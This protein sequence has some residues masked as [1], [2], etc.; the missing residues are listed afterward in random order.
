MPPPGATALRVL[1]GPSA[2]AVFSKRVQ[3]E[4]FPHLDRVPV[5]LAPLAS[6]A[7][8][9]PLLPLLVLMAKRLLL[10]LRLPLI[11]LTAPLVASARVESLLNVVPVR[12]PLLELVFVLVA[13]QALSA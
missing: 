13:L 12:F 4:A 2:L 3:R 7:A 9:V 11:A 6:F 10:A 1:P 5:L 8:W